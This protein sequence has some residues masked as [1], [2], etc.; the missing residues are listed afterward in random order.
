MVGPM[1]EWTGDESGSELPGEIGQSVTFTED[2]RRGGF[3]T[4][5]LE[6]GV[7][8]DRAEGRVAIRT[9]RGRLVVFGATDLEA[10][11]DAVMP[12]EEFDPE[13]D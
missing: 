1:E 3:L 2:V 6:E 8:E 5:R 7:I 12:T 10:Y 13:F 9:A 4:R 11:L